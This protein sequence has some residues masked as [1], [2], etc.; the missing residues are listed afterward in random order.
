M[1]ILKSSV[2]KI[3]KA[4]SGGLS[5]WVTKISGSS[6]RGLL[7]NAILTIGETRK[8]SLWSA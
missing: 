3:V 1:G 7:V 5:V 6:G 2:I 8:Q 4:E